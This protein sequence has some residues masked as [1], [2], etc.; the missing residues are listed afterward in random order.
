M[1]SAGIASIANDEDGLL[2]L[3]KS[4]MGSSSTPALKISSVQL[5][6]LKPGNR[7]A[8]I[9]IA[10]CLQFRSDMQQPTT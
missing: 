1:S 9:N 10:A 4:R 3:L 2:P 7:S 8:Q 5:D 6:P